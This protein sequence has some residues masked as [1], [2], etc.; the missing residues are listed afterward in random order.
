MH[1]AIC[2]QNLHCLTKYK[3]VKELFTAEQLACGTALPMKSS[4]MP[5]LFSNSPLDIFNKN[6]FGVLAFHVNGRWRSQN[7][8]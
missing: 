6:S 1:V 8:Q 7:F 3:L 5:P 4:D 2:R